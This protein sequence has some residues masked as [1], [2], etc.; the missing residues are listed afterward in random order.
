[1]LGGQRGQ[2][3]ET[4]QRGHAVRGKFTGMDAMGIWASVGGRH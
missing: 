2:T 1:M 3:L 4:R